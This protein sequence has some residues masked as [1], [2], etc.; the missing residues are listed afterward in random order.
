MGSATPWNWVRTRQ[1]EG[2]FPGDEKTGVWP[3]N[4]NRILRG[5]GDLSVWSDN[6]DWP[7][8]DASEHDH[9]AKESRIDSYSRVW[10]YT[11]CKRALSRN[12][13]VSAAFYVTELWK[14]PPEGRLDFDQEHLPIVGGHAM[15]LMYPFRES[16]CPLEWDEAEFLVSPNS[17]GQAWGN[18]GWTAVRQE[19]FNRYMYSAWTL[20]VKC[21]MPELFGSGIQHVKWI[22]ESTPERFALAYDIVNVDSNDRMAWLLMTIRRGELHIEDLYVKPE[23]R[24]K[25]FGTALMNEAFETAEKYLSSVP[26]RFWIDFA[27]VDTCPKADFLCRWF[28]KYGLRIEKSPRP[29]A[30]YT[31]Q[32]GKPVS[33]LPA[34][35]IPPKPA[36]VFAES[37]RDLAGTGLIREERLEELKEQHGVSSEFTEIVGQVIKEHAEVLRRLA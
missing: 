21:Q 19:F 15:A 34:V 2:T 10:D 30:A 9:E 24:F 20:D 27:D 26:L 8:E 16:R 3:I 28:G 1:L 29:W 18:A 6:Q 17:W 35:D 37:A 22:R 11:D 13:V 5:W 36:Y 33:K 7:P 25:G 4:G 14:N 31:A 12:G 23:H 32:I